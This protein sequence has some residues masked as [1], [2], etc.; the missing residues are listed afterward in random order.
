MYWFNLLYYNANSYYLVL[1][2]LLCPCLF[3]VIYS[4]CVCACV[5][6]FDLLIYTP[7]EHSVWPSSLLV[8]P[9]FILPTKDFSGLQTQTRFSQKASKELMENDLT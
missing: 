9:S 5:H 7:L 2:L 4:A 3:D 8:S 6:V 1:I